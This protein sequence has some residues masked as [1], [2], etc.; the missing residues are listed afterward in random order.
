MR[1]ATYAEERSER[2]IR[3]YKR[4]CRRQKELRK[5]VLLVIA[6]LACIFILGISCHVIVSSAGMETEGL[7]FKYYTSIEV[8][9]DESLW[10]IADNFRD[11]H[12]ADH[13]EYISEVISI[14]HLQ[15]EQITSGQYLI[16]PYY[17]EEFI[18]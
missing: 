18:K 8:A 7:S 9:P 12:Y 10:S 1:T 15:E 4:K 11:D 5:R 16:V 6:A 13:Q 14:N 2:D 17:S 3:N